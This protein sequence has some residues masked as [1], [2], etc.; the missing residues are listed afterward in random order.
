MCEDKI[1]RGVRALNGV[2]VTVKR[3]Q[4]PWVLVGDE[5]SRS[6][7]GPELILIVIMQIDA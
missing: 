4:E 2:F 6:S 1:T 7:V 3:D 5:R